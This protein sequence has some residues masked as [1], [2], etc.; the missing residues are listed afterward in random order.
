MSYLIA[1]RRVWLTEW[2]YTLIS[3]RREWPMRIALRWW[4]RELR[5]GMLDIPAHAKEIRTH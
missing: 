3:A 1:L 4:L 5:K 2:H